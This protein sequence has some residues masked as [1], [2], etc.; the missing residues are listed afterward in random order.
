L[1]G[2]F[3]KNRGLLNNDPGPEA[4]DTTGVENQPGAGAKNVEK[5]C[6]IAPSIQGKT[7]DFR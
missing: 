2:C 3:I 7:I 4:S 5:P 1:A 6:E